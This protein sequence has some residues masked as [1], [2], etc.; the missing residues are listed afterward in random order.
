MGAVCL[1]C[2]KRPSFGNDISRLGKNALR[3]HVKSRTRRRFNPNIQRVRA[4][5]D[6]SVKR[7]D[8]CT[9]CIKAGRVQ[10]PPRRT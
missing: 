8:V 4:V 9:S 5:V 1:L 3:R 10:K 6:G 2:G 7:I